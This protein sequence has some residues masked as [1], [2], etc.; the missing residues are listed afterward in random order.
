MLIKYAREDFSPVEVAFLQAAIGAMGVLAI[1][2]VEGGR[3]WRLRF[4]ET[5][6]DVPEAMRKPDNTGHRLSYQADVLKG[7]ENRTHNTEDVEWRAATD[8]RARYE[9]AARFDR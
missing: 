5:E 2:L 1:V 9:S 8:R 4:W 6:P 3:R 7:A